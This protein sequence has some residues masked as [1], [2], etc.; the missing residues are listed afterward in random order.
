M[1]CMTLLFSL[2]H[3]CYS[4]VPASICSFSWP[5]VSAKNLQF[6]VESLLWL[7]MTDTPLVSCGNLLE[8]L[9]FSRSVVSDSL[10]AHGQKHN[11]F[12]CPSPSPRTCSNSCPLS[13]WC[14]PTGS[15]S[16]IPF[17]S[18]LH[19]FPELGSFLMSR[20]FASGG[21]SI[22]PSASVLPMNIQG[23]FS[24]GLTDL[25]SL[26]SKGLSRVSFTTTQFKNINS[27]LS[28]F[29]VQLSHPCMTA[30]KTIALIIQ[31]FVSCLG[32]S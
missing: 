14:H 17:S 25:I 1:C 28:F 9:F 10:L 30:G 2:E 11:R 12:P 3:E 24:L 27:L 21:Q 15:L 6:F 22:G 31:T 16:V 29:M 23:W 18:C 13:Q 20:L 8:Q 32:L 19:S 26:E 5:C 4:I 7:G